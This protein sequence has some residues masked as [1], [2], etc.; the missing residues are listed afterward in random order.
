MKKQNL[1]NL[2]FTK[3]T[4]SNMNAI[5]GGEAQRTRGGC[6]PPASTMPWVDSCRISACY[7]CK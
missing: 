1:K 3:R 2:T 7:E 6:V 5:S 4:I